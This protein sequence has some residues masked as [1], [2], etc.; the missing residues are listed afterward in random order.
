MFNRHSLREIR[1]LRGLTATALATAA[2]HSVPYLSQVEHGHRTSPSM[3]AIGKWAEVLGVRPEALYLEPTQDELLRE[4]T[5]L[6]AREAK[7]S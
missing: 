1:K 2:G 6:R 7:S 4:M 5:L 3:D